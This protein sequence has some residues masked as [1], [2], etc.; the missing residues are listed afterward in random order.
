MSIAERILL[1]VSRSPDSE[2]YPPHDEAENTDSQALRL[3][4]RVYPQLDTLVTG[5]RVVDFGCG[6][7]SQ[8]VALAAECKCQVIGIDSN[9]E[10]L[11]KAVRKANERGLLPEQVSFAESITPGMRGK[12]DVV[13]SQNSFEHFPEPEEALDEMCNLLNNSGKLL[14][15]F[16]PPWYAPYGSHMHF[17]CRVPWVNLL[18]SEDAVMGARRHFR[19]DGATTYEQVES[20]LN[21][22]S[23]RKFHSI[24]SA[25]QLRVTYRKLDCVKGIDWLSRIPILHELFINH[26]T[27]LLSK[28]A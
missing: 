9:P 4:R 24:L 2:D 27:V 22:M 23:M 3:L 5:R 11:A 14:I 1:A 18:F 17:F 25:C 19:N 15:T 6:I 28:A 13:I 7:G 16:G 21:Q 12:F 8:S 10:T 26:V 20:G